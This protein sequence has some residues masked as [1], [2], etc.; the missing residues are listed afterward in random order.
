MVSQKVDCIIQIGEEQ[1]KIGDHI[2]S[3]EF[4]FSESRGQSYINFVIY[5]Y[6]GKIANKY[7]TS[8]YKK[9]GLIPVITQTEE[10]AR[11]TTYGNSG[12]SSF[13]NDVNL[14]ADDNGTISRGGVFTPEVNAFLDMIASKEA[15]PGQGLTRVGYFSNNGVPG[16]TGIFKETEAQGGFPIS[17]G[18]SYNIGRYQFAQRDYNHAR[19]T[20]KSITNFLPPNQDKIAYFKLSYRGALPYLLRGEIKKAISKAASE[21]AS[22]PTEGNPRGV[23][24]QVQ[25][26]TT[27]DS[28][29]TFYKARLQYYKSLNTVTNT[30]ASK[31]KDTAGSTPQNADSNYIVKS[32]LNNT[33]QVSFYGEG[34]DGK[35]T[36][37]GEIFNTNTGFTAAHNSLAFGTLVKCTWLV[38]GKSVV[39]KINDRGGFAKLGRQ[40]DLSTVAMQSL[41]DSTNNAIAAGV[42]NCK[43]E[44][45]ENKLTQEVAQK[46][47]A[48]NQALKT[49]ENEK[50]TP[51]ES[52]PEEIAYKGQQIF[53]EVSLDGGKTYGAASFIHQATRTAGMGKHRT[54]FSGV[55]VSWKLNRRVKSTRYSNLT[56]KGLAANIARQNQL[57]LVMKEEGEFIE[58]VAQISLTDWKFLLLICERQGFNVRTIGRQL[59]IDKITT[60][61]SLSGYLITDAIENR[62]IS[63][64]IDDTAQ[65][66]SNFDYSPGTISTSVDPD[67]GTFVSTDK[68]VEAGGS[69]STGQQL[70]PLVQGKNY[71]NPR[72]QDKKKKEFIVNIQRY[73]TPEDI[74]NLTPDTPIFLDLK[75]ENYEFLPGKSW[76]LES[77]I[78]RFDAGVMLSNIVL[79]QLLESTETTVDNGRGGNSQMLDYNN[80]GIGSIS[81]YT[82]RN[83]DGSTVT[84]FEQLNP[85][86]KGTGNYA[87]RSPRSGQA[88]GAISHMRGNPDEL[89]YDFTI[90]KGGSSNVPLPSPVAG[91]VVR[92][93]GSFGE[94][95]IKDSSNRI[96][97]V[98]HMSAIKVKIGDQVLFGSILGTQDRIAGNSNTSGTHCHLQSSEL[99]LRR[100][101]GA[102]ITGNFS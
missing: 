8:S 81:P 38:N 58:N 95:A 100:Y 77:V 31:P 91:V 53:I 84:T 19:E 44:I 96:S 57:E 13:G 72:S 40:L 60:N 5:D 15:A 65:T 2:L 67:T 101:I 88:Q 85:H 21:W 73:T 1:F 75:S 24:N 94:V 71:Q 33:A 46:D 16:S 39:V 7:F 36:A 54:S 98:L 87:V 83:P 59:Y 9:G 12:S 69:S 63:I 82:I 3:F 89:V 22:L 10:N 17:A 102:L 74:E 25:S 37:S 62:I 76:Y 68:K 55:A 66:S 70:P 78:H 41:S 6:N 48:K 92:S 50:N 56:L 97:R 29:E 79:Y 35:K 27:I 47:T 4:S 28:L 80:A 49:V 18:N 90:F 23:Y 45:V 99:I 61:S 42:I 32:V 52:Q 14:S 93:G 20:D 64:D 86:W 43:L 26:G 30:Q 11:S 51:P 34:F